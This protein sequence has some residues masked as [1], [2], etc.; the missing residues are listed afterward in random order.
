MPNKR[1]LVVDQDEMI[2]SILRKSLLGYEPNAGVVCCNESES[3]LQQL[4]HSIYDVVVIDFSILTR[5]DYHFFEE[6]RRTQTPLPV[7]VVT[8]YP[9]SDLTISK[10]GLQISHTLLKPIELGNLN[11]L[12]KK[13]FTNSRSG[14]ISALIITEQLYETSQ[15]MM[16]DLLRDSNARCVVLS[17]TDGRILLQSGATQDM[18]ID[19]VAALL[20]GGFATLLEA[21][22]NLSDDAVINLIYREG[23][24][25]DLYALNIGAR[26]FLVLVIDRGPFYNRLGT[27]WYYARQTAIHLMEKMEKAASI[28]PAQVFDEHSKDAY[29]N[30]LDKLFSELTI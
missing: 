21:G 23:K 30:E 24:I 13:I 10:E 16:D 2:L 19:E 7:I 17:D 15:K 29:N 5:S 8:A 25:S 9:N 1:I 18:A 14:D 6:I 11:T 4:A 22:K 27:V 20:G 28:H 3:A 12:L 26:L